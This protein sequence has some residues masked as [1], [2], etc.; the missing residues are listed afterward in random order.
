MS[1]DIVLS[2]APRTILR[3][4]AIPEIIRI[5]NEYRKIPGAASVYMTFLI[6]NRMGGKYFLT[7]GFYF[8]MPQR[9]YRKVEIQDSDVRLYFAFDHDPPSKG[10]ILEILPC[11]LGDGFYIREVVS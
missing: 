2:D 5:L 11:E 3:K 4:S 8:G 9:E 10:A 6:T 1:N 7:G